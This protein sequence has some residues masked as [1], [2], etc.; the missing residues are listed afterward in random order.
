MGKKIQIINS[1]EEAKKINDWKDKE[2]EYKYENEREIKENCEIKINNKY[3]F[4]NKLSKISCMFDGCSSLTNINLSN[5]KTQNVI[6]M[7]RMF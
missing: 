7:S 2:D 1:F 4:K 5:F 6:N 3:K